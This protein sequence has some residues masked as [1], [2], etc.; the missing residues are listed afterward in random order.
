MGALIS[1]ASGVASTF[2]WMEPARPYLIGITV[3]VLGFAWYQKLK[4]RTAEEIQC[5]CEEDE[6]KTL[7]ADQNI[8]GN[9][10]RVC[11]LDAR[12]SKLCT[13]FLSFKRQQGSCNRQCF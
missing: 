6:K 13:H 12:F 1:G 3:L 7:Y 5:D 2:S 4:P 9:C 8:L 11:S 10:N